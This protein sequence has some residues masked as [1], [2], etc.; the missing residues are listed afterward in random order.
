MPDASPLGPVDPSSVTDETEKSAPWIVR[1][2]AGSMTGR[3]VMSSYESLRAAGTSVVCLSPWGDSSPLLLPCIRFRDLVVHAVIAGT[4]GM[5]AVAAPVMG[6]VADVVVDTLGDSIL[7][8]IGMHAS[9]ELSAKAADDLLIEHPIKHLIPTHSKILETTG[10]K[11]LLITLKY[12]HTVEDASLGF[13]RSSVHKDASLFASVKDYL[14][15]QKGWFSPYLFASGRRPIIPRSMTPDVV[16]CHG[17]FLNGDYKIGETL[18]RESAFNINLCAAS[19]APTPTPA[20]HP[21]TLAPPNPSENHRG[22]S[23]EHRFPVLSKYI[24]HSRSPSP[25]PSPELTPLPQP[26][27]PRRLVLLLLGLKPHRAGIW[28]S[29]QRPGESVINYV[30]LNGCPAIVLPAKLGVPLLAWDGLTLESLQK[31]DVPPEDSQGD[32]NAQQPT[33]D[34]QNKFMG[35]VN[36]LFEYLGLCVDW[37]RVIVPKT[38]SS[39]EEERK[40]ALKGAVTLLVAAAVR[41]KDSKEVKKDV[42]ADRAGIVIFRIP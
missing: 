22:R 38:D 15:I 11:T 17:P 13:F 5:A 14:A 6:P 31:L 39:T 32:A 41:S 37:E 16:F 12:K 28:T 36:V 40:E 7:V 42:D 3:I 29:S 10:T 9:F 4:G 30:L 20:A 33:N 25:T 2:L 8:E 21:Q 23:L 24:P 27:T 35:V 18:L 34:L 19:P 1:K 26:P